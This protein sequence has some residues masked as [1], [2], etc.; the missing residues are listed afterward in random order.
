MICIYAAPS[1]SALYSNYLIALRKWIPCT[2]NAHQN[3]QVSVST[4]DE[5]VF[6]WYLWLLTSQGANSHPANL[7][8]RE[9]AALQTS[10]R[11]NY[12]EGCSC[13]LINRMRNLLR[14]MF[15]LCMAKQYRGCGGKVSPL[16]WYFKFPLMLQSWHLTWSFRN[17]SWER[18]GEK[19]NAAECLEQLISS[20]IGLTRF[21]L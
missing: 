21:F 4:S 14:E 13:C 6:N 19:E 20:R 18:M 5:C 3:A 9:S 8:T 12:T 16:C 15:V 17:H 2:I 11:W 1:I 10:G 7:M